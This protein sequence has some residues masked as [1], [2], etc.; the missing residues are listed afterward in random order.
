MSSSAH[1]LGTEMHGLVS[2]L[3]PIFRSLTGDGVRETL[4]ILREHLPELI[5]HE[6]PTGTR[7][8]DWKIPQEWR[9]RQAYII[10][11]DGKKFCD[12]E[13]NNL[14]LVGYSSPVNR[15][16]S[17]DEL[18]QRL[19]SL[20]EQPDAIPYVTSY[21][22]DCWGFCIADADRKQ[23]KTGDYRVVIDSELFDGSLTYG[24][25]FVP[26]DSDKEV[27]VSTYIC[28]PSMAN[29]ELSG[30]VVAAYAAK[31]VQTLDRRLSYRFVF[32]PETIGAIAFL[33]RQ[34]ENLRN[35]VVAGFNLSCIGDDGGYS[36]VES[37]KGD[38]L[39]DRVTRHVLRHKNADFMEYS[40]L[41]RGS[42]ERQYCSPGIDLPLCTL[43][44]TKFG[45]FPEYHTSKDDLSFVT[46]PGLQGGFDVLINCFQCLESNQT[47]RVTVA[48]EPQL[49]KR[50]LYPTLSVRGNGET[51]RDL[52]DFIAY[53]DGTETL[54]EIAHRLDRPIWSFYETVDQLT[55]HNLIEVVDG[56]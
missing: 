22:R 46:A 20:P 12:I 8:F 9:I 23:L 49:G 43:C 1:Q 5:V 33:S 18:Q 21:Y 3:F 47:Y 27:F 10:D 28:H 34:H 48:C 36:I 50:G 44:R 14:H 17:L 55:N 37:R 52:T 42:D 26:G 7:C 39:A 56:E 11:P 19:H 29:D 35:N 45:E 13:N 41:S 54:L 51:V 4:A 2:R 25:L 40:F 53:C 31:W 6:V 30:P 15:T 32:V 38:T 16:M 24:E